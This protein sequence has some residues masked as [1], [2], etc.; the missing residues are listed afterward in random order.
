VV[1]RKRS[2]LFHIL[3]IDTRKRSVE[4]G[5]W[6]RG[7]LY[8]KRCDVSF[9][10][11]YMIYLALSADASAT[12]NGLCRLPYLRT[13]AHAD[14]F[15]TW[16]GGGYFAAPDVLRTNFHSETFIQSVAQA[17]VPFRVDPAPGPDH[18][19]DLGVLYPRL[20]RD[21][22]QRLG[23]NR[24]S[25]RILPGLKYRVAVDGDDGWGCRPSPRHP[26]LQLRF[27][28][29][30]E[31]GYTFAFQLD[32]YPRLLNGASWACWDSRGDL[33]VAR[34]GLVELYTMKNI[35]RGSIK[36]AWVLDVEPLEP[37]PRP[38]TPAV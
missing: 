8:P 22:F 5:S 28:G 35:G 34:P 25:E 2:K 12:W 3:V 36:P 23:P 7:K 16:F 14:N 19:E 32:A 20:A 13:L 18:S 37:P 38:E 31:H 4:E 27:V 1:Q 30:L 24:G 15:G 10:G 11:Q 17:R 21:G 33:W 26:E 29:Y 9:D 6:F